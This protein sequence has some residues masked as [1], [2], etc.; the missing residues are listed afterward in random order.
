MKTRS[1]L[2]LVVLLLALPACSPAAEEYGCSEMMTAFLD[3]Q[4]SI[5][6]TP[7]HLQVENPL[8]DGNE[9]DPN[10]Y[11]NVLTS[12]SM[13]EGFTL[14]FAYTYDFMGGFP[15]LYARH[16]GWAP[17]LSQ[18]D[19][20]PGIDYFL[21]HVEVKDTPEGYLQFVILAVKSEQFYLFWHANYNDTQIVCNRKALKEIVK[22]LEKT[23]FGI[24]ITLVEK[25]RALDLEA[26][27]PV[28]TFTDTTVTVQVTTFTMWGGFYRQTFTIDRTFPHHI[29]DFQEEQIAPYNCG[30]SF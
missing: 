15:T 14:D 23:T 24:P 20:R 2:L 10:T 22:G 18:A 7:A 21:D 4:N 16:T 27:E 1:T 12:L 6:E 9:F 28:V 11:F 17:F 3:L 5:G 26:I 30:I 19:V 8:E 13:E 29:I 25:T